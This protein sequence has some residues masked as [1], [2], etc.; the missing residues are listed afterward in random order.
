[1]AILF[2]YS[3]VYTIYFY[4]GDGDLVARK[5]IGVDDFQSL[6]DNGGFQQ[7]F[8][9]QMMPISSSLNANDTSTLCLKDDW[10][11]YGG[12]VYGAKDSI[13]GTPCQKPTVSGS[14]QKSRAIAKIMVKDQLTGVFT[15]IPLVYPLG[16]PNRVFISKVKTYEN[17]VYHCYQEPSIS[18]PL[19][20]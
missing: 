19:S 9:A 6:D 1:M 16:Y 17:R 15:H 12:G 13:S 18:V 8:L 11:E 5:D 7:L 3:G 20:N 2:P 14:V 10:T 4:N